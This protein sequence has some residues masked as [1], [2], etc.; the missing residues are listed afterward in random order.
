[1]IAS[2]ISICDLSAQ[3]Y[4]DAIFELGYEPI[5][6]KV[7]H[8][9][10][11]R[12]IE[13]L[14]RFRELI[15][16]NLTA[17][18]DLLTKLRDLDSRITSLDVANVYDFLPYSDSDGLW[19]TIGVRG[20]SDLN[21]YR[22]NVV[23]PN[24]EEWLDSSTADYTGIS[25][26][27]NHFGDIGLGIFIRPARKDTFKFLTEARLYLGDIPAANVMRVINGLLT[28]TWVYAIG[29]ANLPT[30]IFEKN[31]RDRQGIKILNGI[32]NDFPDFFRIISQYCNIENIVSANNK[33]TGDS[34]GF[35]IKVRS[36]RVVFSKHY[37]E[38]GKLLKKWR[39][40]VKFKVRLF[41]NEDRLM[42]R[43]ELDSANNLFTMQFRILRDRFLPILANGILK[44]NN[45]FSL[46]GVNSTQFKIVCDIH[47]NIVG[48]QLKIDS[49]PVI[50]DYR[51]SVGG[52]NFKAR[53]VQPP[54]KIEAGG[55][56]YGVIPVWMVDMLIPSNVHEIMNGFFQTLAM[57]NNGNGSV[58]RI[59]SFPE[60]ASKQSFLLNTDA[61]VLANGT[62]KLGFNLQRKFFAMPPESLVEIRAFKRQ[63]WNA[64]YHDFQRI[65]TKRGYP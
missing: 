49:L 46:T 54:Q 12:R 42:G 32:S 31:A 62:L 6:Q 53:L 8:A 59:Y 35:N 17:S 34:L 14:H 3:S 55:S 15:S 4:W 24:I 50:L 30:E 56:V 57:G 45:G 2:L 26:S 65:K 18:R 38:L 48:M 22:L 43:V 52:P 51:H 41:D 36:N 61:E 64:L 16:G 28:T 19:R 20:Q 10:A 33:D 39:E 25:G 47:L 5:P 21:S 58:V 63:L 9:L 37:P 1:V 40:I 13:G 7:N 29:A 60:Q 23:E 11:C 44:T 27:Q